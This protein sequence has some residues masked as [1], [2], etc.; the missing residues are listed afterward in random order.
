MVSISG[1]IFRA[2]FEGQ[3]G[4]EFDMREKVGLGQNHERSEAEN[5]GILEGLVFAFGDAE[6][7]DFGSFT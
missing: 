6:E 4:I 1:W 7:H 5:A 3:F 2:F